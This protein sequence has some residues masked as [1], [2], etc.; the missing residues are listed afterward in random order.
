VTTS[1]AR[2]GVRQHDGELKSEVNK[3]IWL[4]VGAVLGYGIASLRGRRGS[5]GGVFEDIDGKLREFGRTVRDSY[6]ARQDELREA[7][8]GDGPDERP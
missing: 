7:I 1:G 6:H 8:G 4:G 2:P 5:A 3:L